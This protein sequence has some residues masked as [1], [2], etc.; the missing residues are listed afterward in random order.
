MNCQKC[1]SPVSDDAK[2]CTV[3][4][5]PISR[6][7]EA[8][9]IYCTNCG[10]VISSGNKFC[11]VCGA[12]QN[13]HIPKKRPLAVVLAIVVLVVILGGGY[14]LSAPYVNNFAASRFMSPEKYYK[15]AEKNSVENFSD[16]IG[17]LF[18]AEKEAAMQ[19]SADVSANITVGD[20]LF[21]MADIDLDDVNDT[22][23]SVRS[24]GIN[25]SIS[26]NG[27]LLGA[28]ASFA[29]ENTDILSCEAVMDTDKDSLYITIPDIIDKSIEISDISDELGVSM[30]NMLEYKK[31][32]Q[33]SIPDAQTVK[34]I[35][36]LTVNA[37]SENITE[38]T[39]T[40]ARL[41]IGDNTENCTV[42]DMSLTPSN[43]SDALKAMRDDGRA[44]DIT[45][46]FIK[47]IMDMTEGH[48]EY[49]NC[50]G[51]FSYNLDRLIEDLDEISFDDDSNRL[52][53]TVYVNSKG[54]IIGRK[55]ASP[56]NSFVI[57]S[58]S[59]SKGNDR[60]FEISVSADG[61]EIALTGNGT[62]NSSGFSGTIGINVMR[63]QIAAVELKDFV[64]TP[65]KCSGSGSILP[66]A[67]I[68]KA[69]EYTYG[70]YYDDIFDYITDMGIAFTI[71]SVY[72]K[73]NSLT[74][75]LYRGEDTLLSFNSS[76]TNKSDY[77]PSVP[78]NV[79]DSENL[80]SL[81]FSSVNIQPVL[82]N[83]RSAGIPPTYINLL[84]DELIY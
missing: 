47:N 27:N 59:Y 36:E 58:L 30:R 67:D 9:D 3:C 7:E 21:T 54:K 15:M 79:I 65:E 19:T 40:K 20:S 76:S 32:L 29:L 55:I 28:K 13:Q 63:Y 37:A 69:L 11:T 57:S 17:S 38:V 46:E 73:E 44:A 52:Y 62:S 4:G 72:N 33:A 75:D 66:G 74:L 10:S 41:N 78:T 71:D 83:L 81:D 48:S 31:T 49:H 22:I 42:L 14:A 70:Y 82:D 34:E 60:S 43:I 80:D 53:Y 64:L 2:F 16:A 25:Y 24:A 1:N 23:G 61:D 77:S 39:K 26:E 12:P 35:I 68:N 50:D 84:E 56:D 45:D 51:V 5:T 18:S 8:K 6:P